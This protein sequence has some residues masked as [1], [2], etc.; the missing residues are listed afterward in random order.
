MRAFV[1]V[2]F[3]ESRCACG[4]AHTDRI[5]SP[6]VEMSSDLGNLKA[7]FYSTQRFSQ[8]IRFYAREF[9]RS[10]LGI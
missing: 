6:I 3:V 9:S 7:D 2:F 8:Q 5:E 1:T 4:D 10:I